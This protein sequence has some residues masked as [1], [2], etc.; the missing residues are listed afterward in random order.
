[1]LMRLATKGVARYDELRRFWDINEVVRANEHLDMQDDA[2]WLASE[3]ARHK[4]KS[5]R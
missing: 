1:M 5:R 3:E 4:S 2:E